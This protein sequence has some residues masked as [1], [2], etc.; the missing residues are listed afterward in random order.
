MVF[1]WWYLVVRDD[2][3]ALSV[4]NE[5]PPF[6][7]DIAVAELPPRARASSHIQAKMRVGI[8]VRGHLFFVVVSHPRRRCFNGC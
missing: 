5:T 3:K 6:F 8:F 7:V 4:A 2:A 1:I